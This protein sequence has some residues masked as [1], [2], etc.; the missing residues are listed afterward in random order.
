[1]SESVAVD[2]NVQ[3]S[4]EVD[5]RILTGVGVSQDNLAETMD[6][7]TEAEP[8]AE[9]PAPTQARTD[10]TAPSPCRPGPCRA[11]PVGQL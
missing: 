1:M 5:G 3:V 4:H 9:T 6:R 11:G 8:A 2:P 7:H 10:A